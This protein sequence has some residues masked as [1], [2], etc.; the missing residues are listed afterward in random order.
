MVLLGSARCAEPI[1]EATPIGRLPPCVTQCFFDPFELVSDP[2]LPARVLP[3]RARLASSRQPEP[4]EGMGN[5]DY[6]QFVR[7]EPDGARVLLEADGPGV[8]TRIWFTGREPATQ[9]YRVMDAV[10]LHMEIDGEEVEWTEGQSGVTL[11]TLTSGTLPG[12][13]RPWVAGRDTASNAFLSYV[14]IAFARSVRVWIDEPP[15]N[16][17]LVYYQIDW[18]QLPPG[19]T[20]PSFDGTLDAAQVGAME[21]ATGL[22]VER[23]LDLPEGRASFERALAPG[24]SAV[25]GIDEPT[26]VRAIHVEE[27]G[28]GRLTL[29][30]ELVVDGVSVIA[31]PFARW[32][33]A[34]APTAPHDSALAT[35]T[36][37]S[38][39][40]R[41]PFPVRAGLELRLRNSSAMPVSVR[42][43]I[44][45]D[46]GAPD[47][48]LGALRIS[49]G[50]TETPAVGQNLRLLDVR[51]RGHYAGQFL[52]VRGAE[53]GFF[54]GFWVLEGDHELW[55]DDEHILG[56]GLEDYFGGS[57]YYL[58]SAF[59]LPLAGASFRSAL[60][61][62]GEPEV[63]QY[64]H[65]LLDTIPFERSLRFEYESF[66]AGSAV[67]HCLV[68]Y[69]HDVRP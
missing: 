24:E 5:D 68:W 32:A 47:P 62:P 17:T 45:H 26:T 29:E 65:H 37:S 10:V 49:C 25:L 36:T 35:V 53:P 46:R 69:Q 2:Y 3:G 50:T 20:V 22:W 42:A 55:V 23:T 67:E 4:P 13:N 11:E 52:I 40:F 33:F 8:I 56:T 9:D 16:E 18:R 14:P 61:V 66:L 60:D 51:G 64:R 15:G 30:G 7:V 43:T 31:G 28:S 12:F 48:D 58:R 41:Y 39:T 1:E 63:S 21:A 57:F 6:N 54:T 38:S 59:V 19:Y 27:M 34:A 44:E